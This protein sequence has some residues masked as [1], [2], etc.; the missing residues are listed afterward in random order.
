MSVK[1][2][3]RGRPKVVNWSVESATRM[4]MGLSVTVMGPVCDP[5]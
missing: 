3:E 1:N 2:T 4:I 5:E